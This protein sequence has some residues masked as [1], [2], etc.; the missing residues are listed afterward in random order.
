MYESERSFVSF[1]AHSATLAAHA[2]TRPRTA[3]VMRR[4]I[5]TSA[6]HLLTIDIALASRRA[7]SAC[8]AHAPLSVSAYL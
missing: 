8:L 2:A 5:F 3:T 4:A 1:A 6:N 7:H